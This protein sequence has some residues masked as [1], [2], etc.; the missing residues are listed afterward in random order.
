M[1]AIAPVSPRDFQSTAPTLGRTAKARLDHVQGPLVEFDGEDVR[2]EAGEALGPEDQLD[3]LSLGYV[4]CRV[5]A[6]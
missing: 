1:A 2:G 6:L 5:A 4:Q 3:Q